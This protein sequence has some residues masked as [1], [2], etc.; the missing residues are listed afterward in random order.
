[1]SGVQTE[2]VAAV[3]D[4][5]C[6][7]VKEALAN[8][9]KHAQARMVLVS[10]RLNHDSVSLAIQDD[11]VGAPD[12]VLRS[13]QES[14]LHFGL[15]NMRQQILERSGTFEVTNGEEGGL[16]VKLSVPLTTRPA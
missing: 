15:R 5:L 13:F 16:I 6:A 3:Q 8:V 9:A 1:V 11:G 4:V 7:V 14:Y 10:I 2:A 12:L